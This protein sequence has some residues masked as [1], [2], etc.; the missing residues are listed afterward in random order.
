[1]QNTEFVRGLINKYLRDVSPVD[2]VTHEGVVFLHVSTSTSEHVI[3]HI[4]IKDTNLLLMNWDTDEDGRILNT[5]SGRD[6]DLLTAT[7]P[8]IA[9]IFKKVFPEYFLELSTS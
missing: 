7:E 2:A 3:G 6:L 9:V 8:E 4:F 5:G 1:M